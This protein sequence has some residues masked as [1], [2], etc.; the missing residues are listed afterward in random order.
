MPAHSKLSDADYVERVERAMRI[1]RE[2]S[3]S[4]RVAARIVGLPKTVVQSWEARLRK[5]GRILAT[6]EMVRLA[7]IPLPPA[8]FGR[9]KVREKDVILDVE[10]VTRVIRCTVCGQSAISDDRQLWDLI[11]EI[12]GR[13]LYMLHPCVPT[14]VPPS[15]W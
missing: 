7:Q 15:R 14:A 9:P 11:A 3:L 10:Q 5:G 1:R 12:S 2:S 8:R 13:H 4:V 6:R